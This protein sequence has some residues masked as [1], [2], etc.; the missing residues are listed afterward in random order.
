MNPTYSG[1]PPLFASEQMGHEFTA[2][3]D[4]LSTLDNT[5]DFPS[6]SLQQDTTSQSSNLFNQSQNAE[7]NSSSNNLPSSMTT[8]AG[9]SVTTTATTTTA[10]PANPTEKFIFTAADPMD[11]SIPERLTQ[12]IHAKYEA[13][14]LKPFDYSSGYARLQNFMDF[15]MSSES[16]QRILNV[17]GLFRPA[18]R[19]V[20]GQLRDIDLVL[21]E[22]T[23]E[24]LLLEYDRAFL[25]MGIPACLWRRTGEIYKANHGK[26]CFFIIILIIICCCWSLLS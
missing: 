25:T 23:F 9:S 20:A 5:F 17:M 24:R 4:F 15:H 14:L 11:G 26:F 16:R 3:S 21:V 18:F 10:P 12:I 6:S 22:E 8:T 19:A 7:Q 1:I 13:G 2:L